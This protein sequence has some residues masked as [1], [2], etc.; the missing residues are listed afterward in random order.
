MVA[1]QFMTETDGS[2]EL[3]LQLPRKHR[4]ESRGTIWC[5]YNNKELR[6]KDYSHPAS[7]CFAYQS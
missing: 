7:S 5:R 2:N 1:L 4:K 3:S 6:T